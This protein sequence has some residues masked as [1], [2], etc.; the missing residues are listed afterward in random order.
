[1]N[2]TAGQ[3]TCTVVPRAGHFVKMVH[4]GV[5]CVDASYEGLDVFRNANSQV[6]RVLPL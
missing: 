6:I 2:S 5:E 1:M 3:A 4:N